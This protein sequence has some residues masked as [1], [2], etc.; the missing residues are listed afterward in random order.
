[1]RAAAS[2]DRQVRGGPRPDS[3]ATRA[4]TA[5][6]FPDRENRCD[7][8]CRLWAAYVDPVLSPQSHRTH[9][10]LR[11]VIAQFKFRIFQESCKFPPR[12]E[13]VL[14]GLAEYTGG[15]C[16]GL[17]CLDLV[18]DIIQQSGSWISTADNR[19]RHSSRPA[20]GQN[21]GSGWIVGK[22]HLTLQRPDSEHV[23]Q[24][25]P[26]VAAGLAQ[27]KKSSGN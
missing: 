19:V 13:Q 1:M 24:F 9:R 3:R 10:I 25:V 15:Q 17:C 26:G 6:S 4:S 18:T 12:C 22:P 7:L 11:Q 8:R 5:D 27:T 16:N 2:A 23:P 14:A 21:A 20:E